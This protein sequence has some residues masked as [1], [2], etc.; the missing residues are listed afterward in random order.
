MGGLY[1]L[2]LGVL[3]S[4]SAHTSCVRACTEACSLAAGWGEERRDEEL[5]MG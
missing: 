3:H 1:D 4:A 5:T 2:T